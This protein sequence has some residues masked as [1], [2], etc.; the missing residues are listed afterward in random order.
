MNFVRQKEKSCR[1][2]AKRAAEQ[3][4]ALYLFILYAKEAGMVSFEPRGV[5]LTATSALPM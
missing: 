2:F 5:W 4:A 1:F 3:A